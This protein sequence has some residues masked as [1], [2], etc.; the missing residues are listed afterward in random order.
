MTAEKLDT[1]SKALALNLDAS[2]FGSF[3]EIGAGQETARWFLR[4][5]AASGTVAKTICAYD[6]AVSDDLYGSGSRYVSKERLEAM[7]KAEWSH[8]EQQTAERS[9]S[10]RS[11]VFANTVSARNYAGTNQCH[12]WLGIQFRLQPGAAPNG[13]V[14]H[15]N[16]LDPT[17]VLQQQS[18]GILG[19]N[20]VYAAY[21]QLQTADTFLAGL[22]EELGLEHLEIDFIETYGDLFQAWDRRRLFVSLVADGLAASVVLPHAGDYLPLGEVFYKTPVVLE[23]GRFEEHESIHTEMLAVGIKQLAASRQ[24]GERAPRGIF[25]LSPSAHQAATLLERAE[26][27]LDEGHDVLL[28]KHFEMYKISSHLR[29][30][31][32]EPIR[33]VIGLS[34]LVRL[35]ESSYAEL[36]GQILEGLGRLFTE[37]VRLYVHPMSESV[38]RGRLPGKTFEGWQIPQSLQSIEADRIV[39]PRPLDALYSYLL[40]SALIEPLRSHPELR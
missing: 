40:A 18:L 16:L 25:C 24:P 30:F 21:H 31:T 7:L 26:K 9:A 2:I 14:L 5:G 37:H 12:G 4:V 19:V 23:P 38:L 17:N 3:A 27:L 39:P 22:A 11:F 33:F 20:L 32:T 6:K 15:V 28:T 13:I 1:H 35:I 10:T 36:H 8:L 29:A 34:V